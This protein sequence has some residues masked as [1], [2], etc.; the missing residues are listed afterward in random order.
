MAFPLSSLIFMILFF[1]FMFYTV[2][3]GLWASTFVFGRISLEVAVSCFEDPLKK[4]SGGQTPLEY[5]QSKQRPGPRP[6]I[7]RIFCCF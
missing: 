4:N 6:S 5:A 3:R 7:S 2:S 1:V